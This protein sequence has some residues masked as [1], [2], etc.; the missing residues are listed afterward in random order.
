MNNCAS[1]EYVGIYLADGTIRKSGQECAQ[2]YA[3]RHDKRRKPRNKIFA[4]G[5]QQLKININVPYS[6]FATLLSAKYQTPCVESWL[7]FD[8]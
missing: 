5:H 2:I 8:R 1:N 7:F 6:V 4:R 3:E